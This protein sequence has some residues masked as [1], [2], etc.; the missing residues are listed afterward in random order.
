MLKIYKSTLLLTMVAVAQAAASL[1]IQKVAPLL[2]YGCDAFH[3]FGEDPMQESMTKET[4]HAVLTRDCEVL[5]NIVDLKV[6]QAIH[7]F[8]TLDEGGQQEFSSSF[9]GFMIKEV[10]YIGSLL[11]I[12]LL[13]ARRDTTAQET[14]DSFK[15]IQCLLDRA[16]GSP[17]NGL[18]II[19][20]IVS[21]ENKHAMRTMTLPFTLHDLA[22]LIG[23]QEIVGL[24]PVATE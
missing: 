22:S 13:N 8:D 1:D 3:R 17:K 15:V 24:F 11:A 20:K 12:A 2:S 5:K 18:V 10:R 21:A 16:D 19:L 4:V 23:S 7:V 6:N 9:P 14:E